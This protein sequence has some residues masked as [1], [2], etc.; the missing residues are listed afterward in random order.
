[1]LIFGCVCVGLL[2]GFVVV[3]VEELFVD[4]EFLVVGFS[5][6]LIIVLFFMMW[7]RMVSMD[8][9][10]CGLYFLGSFCF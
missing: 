8:F 1:M 3:V 7:Y 9:V 5:F 4:D 2:V 6:F 10:M